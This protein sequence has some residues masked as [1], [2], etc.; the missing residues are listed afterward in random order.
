[1]AEE[2]VRDDPP[3]QHL[4]LLGVLCGLLAGNY[5]Q[6]HARVDFPD[7]PLVPRLDP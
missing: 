5:T 3:D 1:V 4:G 7:Q 2:L 6:V